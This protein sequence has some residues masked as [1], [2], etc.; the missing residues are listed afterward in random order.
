[1]SRTA[2]RLPPVYMIGR[3]GLWLC[4]GESGMRGRGDCLNSLRSDAIREKAQ[5]LTEGPQSLPREGKRD[6]R[7]TVTAGE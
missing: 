1:M 7:G 5:A 3:F 2:E 4:Q 6:A